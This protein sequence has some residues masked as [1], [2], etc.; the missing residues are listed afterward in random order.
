MGKSKTKY[1][2]TLSGIF[3]HSTVLII[4]IDK[5]FALDHLKRTLGCAYTGPLEY[6]AGRIS[7]RVAV[8]CKYFVGIASRLKE[9]D[10]LLWTCALVSL[11]PILCQFLGT[12]K[13]QY[14]SRRFSRPLRAT[15]QH[16]SKQWCV[17]HAQGHKAGLDYFF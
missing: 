10:H 5:N 6:L 17:C 7:G 13:I 8:P 2:K 16:H 9:A 3:H 1:I 11:S 14:V 15:V 4:F 12:V